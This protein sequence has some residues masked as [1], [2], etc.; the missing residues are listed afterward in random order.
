M[1]AVPSTHYSLLHQMTFVDAWEEGLTEPLV[2]WSPRK[3]DDPLQSSVET[4]CSPALKAITSDQPQGLDSSHPQ[5]VPA[6]ASA[7]QAKTL[8]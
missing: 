6:E 4:G 2:G 7:T 5:T 3:N 8:C 1:K